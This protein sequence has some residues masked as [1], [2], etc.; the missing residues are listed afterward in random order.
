MFPFALFPLTRTLI[1]HIFPRL[2]PCPL[3][4]K[5]FFVIFSRKP[6]MAS[7]CNNSFS[8]HFHLQDTVL[9]YSVFLIIYLLTYNTFFFLFLVSVFHILL[10][11]KLLEIKKSVWLLR[12][13]S[14]FRQSAY[15]PN[16]ASADRLGFF[17][18][19]KS[20]FASRYRFS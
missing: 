6:V 7:Q 8:F 9:F 4:L 16:R 20:E 3:L 15:S 5:S 14:Y 18:L 13:D 19:A 12:S 10:E 17:L 11:C 1:S 2:S